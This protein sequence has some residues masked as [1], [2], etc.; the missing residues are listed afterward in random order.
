MLMQRI[1]TGLAMAVP[2]VLLILFAPARI[3]DAL[4]GFLIL[5]AAWEWSALTGLDRTVSRLGFV[6]LAAATMV[7]A[8]V[9]AGP[10]TELFAPLLVLNAEGADRAPREDPSSSR[11][12][13]ARPGTVFRSAS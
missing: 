7:L 2:A 1:R 12:S 6:A 4:I 13:A 9:A 8:A 10:G 3:L 11:A 5:G